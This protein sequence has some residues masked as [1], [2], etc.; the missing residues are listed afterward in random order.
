[1]WSFS[2]T[3]T[4][5]TPPPQ[6]AAK[7]VDF[8]RD[9]RPI[10]SDTCF[11]CHGPDGNARM[12]NLRLDETEGLFV[13]RGGYR[14]IVPG[15]SAQSKLYQKIGSKDDAFRMPPVY[16]GRTLTPAQIELFKKWIDQG[17]KWDTLWSLV[18]PKRPP[19]PEIMDKT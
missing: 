1:M 7:P 8:N 11:K 3:R 17:A 14:I 15:N 2:A 13:D 12:A 9:I 16:S 18:P 19:V 6:A 10:L 4:S 5:S